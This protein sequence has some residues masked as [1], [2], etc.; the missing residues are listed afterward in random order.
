MYTPLYMSI[1]L[2]LNWFLV[3][4]FYT[5]IFFLEDNTHDYIMLLKLYQATMTLYPGGYKGSLPPMEIISTAIDKAIDIKLSQ[6]IDDFP[7]KAALEHGLGGDDY[8]LTGVKSQLG[9]YIGL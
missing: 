6:F 7:L 2:I 1:V 5:S 8:V 3:F 4:L 9:H